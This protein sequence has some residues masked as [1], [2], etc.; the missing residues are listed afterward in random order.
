M[1]SMIEQLAEYASA[2]RYEELPA[3]AVHEC[4]R[5][6]IDTLGCAAGAFNARPTVIARAIAKRAVGDPPARILGSQ[7]ASTP[8]LAAFANGVAMRYLDFNDATFGKSAGHPSDIFGAVL[9][10]ADAVHADGRTVMTAATL[11]YEVFCNLA[12]NV[13][14]DQGWDHTVFGVIASA[15]G[16]AKVLGLTREQMGNAVSLAVVPNLALEQTRTG[17]L[18]MWKGCA[19]ANASRNGVFAAQLAREGLTGPEQAIEGKYG[20]WRMLG[21]F[22]WQPFGGRGG[23]YRVT[24]THIKYFPAV[25]HAQ[26]P[27]TVALELHGRMPPEEI[28]ALAIETYWIAERYADRSNALWRPAT[29]ETADHSI[30]Y[31]VIAALIDGGITEASFEEARIRDRLINR[32]LERATMS[33]NPA[34]TRAHPDEW[35]CRIE[36]TGR[37]GMKQSAEARYFK[38][39]AKRPLSD[40]EIEGKFRA[41]AHRALP[42]ARIDGILKKA[43]SLEELS[44]VDELLALFDYRLR[45]GDEVTE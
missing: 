16:A 44:D 28:E 14:R 33:E 1:D 37:G 8:E 42:R 23:P 15:V 39:H 29:R 40:P 9:A 13:M 26:T 41:L 5:R 20:L 12:E 45:P 10:A 24:Q 17:E 31:C 43:W 38:G 22:Q 6:L 7:E 2:L 19:A 18:A 27:I 3:D 32:L 21:K 34:Y 30:P 35:R 11:A 36:A 25:I 4:K